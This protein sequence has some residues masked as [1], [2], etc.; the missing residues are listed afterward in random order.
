MNNGDIVIINSD[1][2]PTWNGCSG[3]IVEVRPASRTV[4]V[5]LPGGDRLAFS[6]HEIEPRIQAATNH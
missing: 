6:Q 3:E 5:R 1:I 4:I 2:E